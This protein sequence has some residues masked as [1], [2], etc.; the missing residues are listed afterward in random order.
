MNWKAMFR[1]VNRRDFS[2]KAAFIPL[3]AALA[4]SE[5]VSSAEPAKEKVSGIG[6]FFFVANDPEGL[7]N[8]YLDHL[9]IDLAPQFSGGAPWQQEAGFTVFDPFPVG[10][11]MIPSGKHWMIN[12][13]VG[14]LARMISQLK[15]A[16]VAVSEVETYPHG[17][18]ATLA[19]PEGNG[20][21]L[22]E[23]ALP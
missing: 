8:W 9:G 21:Q 15:A 22:W 18:F 19:D 20:I 7:R 6:G 5:A 17:K 16:G 10:N 23:P 14:N 13:R 2:A 12:F 1:S 3:A 11:T 4:S